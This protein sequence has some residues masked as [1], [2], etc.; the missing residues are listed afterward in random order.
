MPLP[1][2]DPPP[3]PSVSAT[4]PSAV[5]IV[6]LLGTLAVVAARGRYSGRCYRGPCAHAWSSRVASDALRLAGTHPPASHPIGSS[7]PTAAQVE[8]GQDAL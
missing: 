2:A 5:P 3:V 6:V 7:L 8:L 4:A 1:P